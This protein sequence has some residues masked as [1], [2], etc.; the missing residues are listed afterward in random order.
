MALAEMGQVHPNLVGSASK[1]SVAFAYGNSDFVV[2]PR[3]EINL[4][5]FR[6]YEASALG[7]IPVVVANTTELDHTFRGIGSASRPPWL[8]A[9]TWEDAKWM[10]C[11]AH[12][13]STLSQKII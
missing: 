8:F 10:V 1:A 11:E 7:A 9:E 2:S 12:N 4:D 5:C 13:N 3:G 6:H